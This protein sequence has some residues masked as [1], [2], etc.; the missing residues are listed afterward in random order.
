ML[1]PSSSILLHAARVRLV[2]YFILFFRR[3]IWINDALRNSTGRERERRER[4]RPSSLIDKKKRATK[5]GAALKNGIRI[6]LLML[7]RRCPRTRRR[8]G[9]GGL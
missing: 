4:Q 8:S 5:P 6:V 2:S 7:A 3:G 9:G 1:L